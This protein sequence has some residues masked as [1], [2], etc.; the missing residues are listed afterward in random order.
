MKRVGIRGAWRV[1]CFDVGG[2][3]GGGEDF[4]R[5]YLNRRAVL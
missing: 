3:S 2:C 1:F 5:Q 4:A